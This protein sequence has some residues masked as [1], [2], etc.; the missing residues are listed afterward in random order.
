MALQPSPQPLDAKDDLGAAAARITE[1]SASAATVGA[2]QSFT[3]GRR[4]FYALHDL[5][6]ALDALVAAGMYLLWQPSPRHRHGTNL[7]L[8]LS[9]LLLTT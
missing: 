6:E 4:V 5:L 2:S 3:A 1:A 9:H 8:I 7:I